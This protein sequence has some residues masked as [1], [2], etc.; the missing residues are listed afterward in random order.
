MKWRIYRGA[1]WSDMYVVGPAAR[2]REGWVYVTDHEGEAV[3]AGKLGYHL[4]AQARG[5]SVG[6]DGL[7]VPREP[8]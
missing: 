3:D 7:A 2:P 1:D 4:S 5:Y 8:N 6:R